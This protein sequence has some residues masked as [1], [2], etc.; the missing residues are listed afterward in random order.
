MSADQIA[1]LLELAGRLPEVRE[2]V[3][4]GWV[5]L[6]SIQVKSS[7]SGPNDVEAQVFDPERGFVPFA[8]PPKELLRVA[9]SSEW[10]AGRTDFLPPVAIEAGLAGTIEA[11]LQHEGGLVHGAV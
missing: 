8:C 1:G 2:L 10:Y 5:R 7:A 9:T 4:R 6:C 11:K 3:E